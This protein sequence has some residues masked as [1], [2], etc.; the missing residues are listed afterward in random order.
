MGTRR[1][2]GCLSRV[3]WPQNRKKKTLQHYIKEVRN[4]LAFL[5]KSIDTVT[6][7]D[8]RM[9]YGYMR[10]KRGI[11]AITMQTRLHYLSSFFDFLV[12]EELI[13]SNP[14]KK[15]GSVKIEKEIKKPFSPEE[16][17]RIPG[18]M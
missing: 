10:E 7:M 14:V 8:L 5:G 2:S 17:E 18:G 11:K 15:V 9:Y 13:R 6:G 16:M 1:R 4:V 3:S 12:T